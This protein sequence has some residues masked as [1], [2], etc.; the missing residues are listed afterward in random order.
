MPKFAKKYADLYGEMKK[1]VGNYISDVRG[2]RFPGSEHS[3]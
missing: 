2:G 3:F 1:A